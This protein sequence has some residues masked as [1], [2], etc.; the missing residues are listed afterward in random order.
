MRLGVGA[1]GVVH[2]VGGDERELELA[3][4]ADEDPVENGLLG[5]AVVLELD[6]ERAR[7]ERISKQSEHFAPAA[8]SLL[9]HGLRHEPAH[10]PRHPD[11]ALRRA[12]RSPRLRAARALT[13]ARET[14]QTRFL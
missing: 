9:E 2:V 8:L 4:E 10:A 5:Q 12:R 1:L 14:S 11:E 3:R 13:C 6:V 7:L